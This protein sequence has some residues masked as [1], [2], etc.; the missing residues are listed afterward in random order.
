MSS[1]NTAWQRE[2]AE[3]FTSVDSLC[4]HLEIA[5]DKLP[6]HAVYQNFPLK[7]P[8]GFAD[9]MERGNPDDPLLRQVLPTTAELHDYPGYSHDPVGDLAAT[10]AP[11]IIHKYRGRVLLIATG[12][13]AV[14][15]RYCF[16][17]N[18]PYTEQQLDGRNVEQAIAYIANRPDITEVI[19]SGGDPLLLGDNKLAR[20]LARL[21]DIPHVRRLRI[22]SRLPVVLPARITAELLA[23]LTATG[24][25]LIMVLHANHAN[26][27]SS[28][29]AAACSLMKAHDVALLN[30]SVLL[31]GVNDVAES[32]CRL[33]EG[34][35]EIGVLPYYLHLLDQASGT[36]HF[37]VDTPRALE[38]YRYMQE[39]LPGYL[40]PRLVREQAGAACKL[41]V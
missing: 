27:L 13:C 33:S 17:R 15:C 12:A 40:L 31:K 21:T 34:L 18:F 23:N 25:Q 2:L 41:P 30:Q 7:V 22:H 6:Q 11:G 10:P 26:E 24:K 3:A 29:V 19:L 1:G 37:A 32:L 4:R 36:G 39:N 14:H 8:K 20:L 9:C 38:L 35:F 28:E 16:R 5:A